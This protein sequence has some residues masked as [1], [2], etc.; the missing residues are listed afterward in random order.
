MSQELLEVTI[1]LKEGHLVQA[2]K[3]G[4]SLAANVGTSPVPH[5]ATDFV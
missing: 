1:Y 2:D 5:L 3:V 4:I